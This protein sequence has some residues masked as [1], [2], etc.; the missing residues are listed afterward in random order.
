MKVKEIIKRL[1]SE[2]W[3]QLRQKGSHRIFKKTGETEL[4]VLPDHGKNKSLQQVFKRT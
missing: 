1:E 3:V 2:G 4:I